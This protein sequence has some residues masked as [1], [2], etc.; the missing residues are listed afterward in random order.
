[1]D[2]NLILGFLGH[3]PPNQGPEPKPNDVFTVKIQG[4]TL[5]IQIFTN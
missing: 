4:Q 5:Q 2:N 1:M 3:N